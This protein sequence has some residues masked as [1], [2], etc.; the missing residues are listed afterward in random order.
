RRAW[1]AELRRVGEVEA[2]PPE[3]HTMSLSNPEILEQREVPGLLRGRVEQADAGVSVAQGSWQE[4][5]GAR[6]AVA[7]RPHKGVDVEPVIQIPVVSNPQ[8]NSACRDVGPGRARTPNI[9]RIPVLADS[10]R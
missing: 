10:H 3:L 7:L 4:Q 5:S 6:A 9:L 2:L 8:D 1:R